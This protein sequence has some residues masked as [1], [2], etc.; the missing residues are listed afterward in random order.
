MEQVTKTLLL[1]AEDRDERQ[2]MA[3]FF[4]QYQYITYM[5]G[6]IQEA[7]DLFF[8]KNHQIDIVILEGKAEKSGVKEW[9]RNV[10]DY[11]DIPIILLMDALSDE[12]YLEYME[13]GADHCMKTP[14][15]R[16][17]L[18]AYV[19]NL[20]C[21]R[22]LYRKKEELY[23]NLRIDRGA[24]KAY[25]DDEDMCL[26]P[27][28][29][30][31]LDYMVQN[32]NVVLTREAILNA[33]WGYDYQGDIRTVDTLIKQLRKKMTLECAYIHSIYG[34]GYRFEER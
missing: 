32:K 4:G 24:R 17:I 18:K 8:S 34:I 6:G 1:I 27:K 23:G 5:T 20:Y 26:T 10:R 19:D 3:N 30:A 7:Q 28:E 2:K 12:R 29:Y 9:I 22:R 14:F 15:N 25:I 11:S 31:V 21:R 33:V 16:K 13:A